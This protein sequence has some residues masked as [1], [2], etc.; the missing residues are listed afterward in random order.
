[1]SVNPPEPKYI[2]EMFHKLP[3]PN[4]R[5]T[6]LLVCAT[7]IANSTIIMKNLIVQVRAP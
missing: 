6:I 3:V 2:S 7:Y 4:Q 1:M 5:L